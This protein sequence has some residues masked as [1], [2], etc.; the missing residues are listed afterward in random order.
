MQ[1]DLTPRR[2]LPHKRFAP[3]SPC[4]YSEKDFEAYN[5]RDDAT[6]QLWKRGTNP[7]TGRKVQVG[8]R[9][10]ARVGRMFRTGS[11]GWPFEV[12]E[13]IDQAQYN[14]ETARLVSEHRREVEAVRA[15]NEER[16]AAVEQ[17][18]RLKWNETVMFDGVHFGIPEVHYDI[19]RRDD[20]MGRMN[21]KETWTEDVGRD[22]CF[23]CTFVY[24]TFTRHECEMCGHQIVE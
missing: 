24:R 15:Y 10:H 9:T 5:E 4:R 21:A 11:C 14:T 23:D 3:S 1:A 6:Y 2:R 7:Q 17:I 12:L 22:R 20:C 19:H 16:D 13:G 18:G 8:G